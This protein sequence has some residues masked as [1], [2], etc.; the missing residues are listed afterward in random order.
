MFIFITIKDKESKMSSN[1]GSVNKD[2]IQVLKINNN[3][4]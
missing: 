3:K 2:E 1:S 4:F